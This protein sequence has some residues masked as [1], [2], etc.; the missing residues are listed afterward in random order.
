MDCK[1]AR[2]AMHEYLDGASEAGQL[3]ALKH[4]LSECA[5]CRHH[6]DRLAQADA[7][8]RS[9]QVPDLP[10]DL[11]DKIMASLPRLPGRTRFMLWLKRHPAAAVA[12]FFL[13][14]MMGSMATLWEK[15]TTLIVKGT[16][17]D[18]VVI[19][20]DLVIVPEGS[21]ING[22]LTVE[23]G[24]LLVEGEI[25]GDLVVIDGTMNMASTAH[26]AGQ[27]KRIDQAIEY[28]WFRVK[29]FFAGFSNNRQLFAQIVLSN[30]RQ[31]FFVG[32][33]NLLC[34]ARVSPLVY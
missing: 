12:V 3:S 4:H 34:I 14:M 29:S 13:F 16:D 30:A 10:D 27:I 19:E 22:D 15:D 1:I 9:V 2:R 18:E 32:D 8:I 21:V 26:I 25:R 23:N 31:S 5:S 7:L 6:L 28:V 17:L 11:T 20:G 24:R 33:G